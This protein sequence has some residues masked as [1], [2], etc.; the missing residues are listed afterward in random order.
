[1]SICSIEEKPCSKCAVVKPLVEFNRQKGA[2]LGRRAICRA[3]AKA[4]YYEPKKAHLIAIGIERR[5]ANPEPVREN[6]RK[7]YAN[8]REARVA[9]AAAYRDADRE[10]WRAI[11]RKSDAK[12]RSTPRGRLDNAISAN[13]SG[14]LAKNAKAGRS[15]QALVGYSMDELIAHLEKQFLPGMTWENY[16]EWHVDHIV[17]KSA[18]N[19]E[20]PEHIDFQRCWA[21]ANLRPLW[22]L[23]NISKRDRI[24]APF[25]PSLAL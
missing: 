18:F 4:L 19:Y 20:A 24:S 1:M 25:Q 5:R 15:W 2:P 11:L 16:G 17:P 14:S 12:R 7:R 3:C 13:M 9:A 6:A 10:K 21:L 23:Q 8:N 22:A